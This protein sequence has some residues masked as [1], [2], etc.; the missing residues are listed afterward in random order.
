MPTIK[1]DDDKNKLIAKLQEDVKR[2]VEAK[3]QY[4][5]QVQSQQGTKAAADSGFYVK[6]PYPK[7]PYVKVPYIKI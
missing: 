3:Y 4:A 6:I 1:N 7:T 2:A 5:R